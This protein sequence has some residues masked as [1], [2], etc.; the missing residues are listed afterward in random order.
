M[1]DG[2]S[3]RG[4]SIQSSFPNSVH[5]YLFQVLTRYRELGGKTP[6]VLF[7]PSANETQIIELV[8]DL[9]SH[10][11][12]I[13]IEDVL[14]V[15]LDI[16]LSALV[17]GASQ[18]MVVYPL[19]HPKTQQAIQEEFIKGRHFLATLGIQGNRSSTTRLQTSMSIKHHSRRCCS[20]WTKNSKALKENDSRGL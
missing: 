3:N 7:Y 16:W 12:P 14:A 2:L 15:G 5:D 6:C 17:Y 13:E 19:L 8:A 18:V 11:I 1:C 9:P 4:D 10:V 20:L